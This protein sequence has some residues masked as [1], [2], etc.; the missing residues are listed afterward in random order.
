[1]GRRGHAAG[2]CACRLV[3]ERVR[4]SA[5]SNALPNHGGGPASDSSSG[6]AATA[7]DWAPRAQISEQR[8]QRPASR[9]SEDFAVRACAPARPSEPYFLYGAA[10]VRGRKPLSRQKP[11]EIASRLLD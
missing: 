4:L 10:K 9:I 2:A 7:D 5:S 6:V 1:M 8:L 3:V 11:K